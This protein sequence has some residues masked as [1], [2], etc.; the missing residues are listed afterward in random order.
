MGDCAYICV[1]VN[2]VCLFVPKTVP[3]M[4]LWVCSCSMYI[5]ICWGIVC[6]DV[7]T[8]VHLV[9]K[10]VCGFYVYPCVSVYLVYAVC[11]SKCVCSMDILVS[12]CMCVSVF[13]ACAPGFLSVYFSSEALPPAPWM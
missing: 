4:S 3:G 13:S 8:T 11:A 6:P 2:F 7:P 10:E 9:G 12:L 1:S 5:S